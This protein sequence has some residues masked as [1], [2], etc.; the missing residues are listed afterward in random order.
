MEDADYF[1]FFQLHLDDSRGMPGRSGLECRDTTGECLPCLGANQGSCRPAQ[2]TH[3]LGQGR[4]ARLP[5]V[6]I[7]LTPADRRNEW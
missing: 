4:R 7:D 6:S 3:R 1:R 2:A 5:R